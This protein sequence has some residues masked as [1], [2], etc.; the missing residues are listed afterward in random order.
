MAYFRKIGEVAPE[1]NELES[2]IH[3]AL[4]SNFDKSASR[5][6]V[7][8]DIFS[9]SPREGSAFLAPS[10][11]PR[12]VSH[13]FDSSQKLDLNH[14]LQETNRKFKFQLEECQ[15]KLLEA[16][17]RASSAEFELRALQSSMS[18]GD[19]DLSIEVSQISKRLPSP[20][21]GNY[22]KGSVS[23]RPASR[24]GGD[25]SDLRCENLL[26]VIDDLRARLASSTQHFVHRS[27]SAAGDESD[28]W[29]F[30][31]LREQLR[32]A[33]NVA[34][35]QSKKKD[36]ALSS[37]RDVAASCKK[38]IRNTPQYLLPEGLNVEKSHEE[39]SADAHQS[40]QFL[41]QAYNSIISRV[42]SLERQN[43]NLEHKWNEAS[44]TLTSVQKMQKSDVDA[45]QGRIFDILASH[46][47]KADS[48]GQPNTFS[49]ASGER[50]TTRNLSSD[51]LHSESRSP[52]YEK[53]KCFHM[54][55]RLIDKNVFMQD[56]LE[57]LAGNM[58]DQVALVDSIL[59]EFQKL[60]KCK[61]SDSQF[62]SIQRSFQFIHQELVRLD[63]CFHL[64]TKRP[65]SESFSDHW[66][67]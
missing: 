48:S 11:T 52:A 15:Q 9:L 3:S 67:V 64:I 55:Q 33:D 63:E 16:E 29:R 62:Y 8:Y 24:N 31:A 25:E 2:F 53:Q 6:K 10:T 12:E 30:A 32:W 1:K 41:L 65:S 21:P 26:L 42:L 18:P 46:L 47:D 39:P 19:V 45:F 49:R 28:L 56:I 27:Q 37:L 22:L 4:S 60:A 50:K 14:A 43:Q 7:N 61:S 5:P 36:A 35:E 34:M 20:G 59:A 57:K 51:F 38:C 13:I 17:Q 54:L 58:N 66:H 40:L 23:R 44:K